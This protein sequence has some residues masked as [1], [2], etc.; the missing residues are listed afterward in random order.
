MN[1]GAAGAVTHHDKKDVGNREILRFILQE[2]EGETVH[3][4]ISL[5]IIIHSDSLYSGDLL[6]VSSYRR[7]KHRG[8]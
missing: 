6:R 7:G 8:E 1:S 2:L 5:F 4:K 3:T